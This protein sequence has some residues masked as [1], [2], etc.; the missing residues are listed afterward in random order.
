[1]VSSRSPS[2]NQQHML[3]RSTGAAT[4]GTGGGL[5]TLA[6]ARPASTASQPL[7]LAL[8]T[9]FSFGEEKYCALSL[10]I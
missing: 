1:M 5:L 6:V 10:S 4:R 9:I 8:S 7:T 2:R 3:V